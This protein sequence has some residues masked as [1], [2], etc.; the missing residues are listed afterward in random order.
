LSEAILSSGTRRCEEVGANSFSR[1]GLVFHNLDSTADRWWSR[2]VSHG[3][4][5]WNA[6]IS[7]N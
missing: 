2:V 4:G 5:R 1:A 3:E 7:N 6:E